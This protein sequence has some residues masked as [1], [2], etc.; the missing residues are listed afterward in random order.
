M[1]I[2]N[3]Y[4]RP[5]IHDRVVGTLVGSALGDAI[6]LYTEFLPASQCAFVYPGAKFSLIEPTTPL[7][8][9]THRLP[10][11][12]GSWTDDTDAAISLLLSY[13]HRAGE[14]LRQQREKQKDGNTK[15]VEIPDPDPKDFE[16]AYI[17]GH[18]K[19]CVHLILC[20]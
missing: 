3:E 16:S 7:M 8:K 6:G 1:D 5:I 13:L 2:R 20:H 9:D 14:A 10:H 19:A 12:P 11:K 17:F 18:P 4:H 15:V